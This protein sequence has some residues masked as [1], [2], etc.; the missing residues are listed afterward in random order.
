MTLVF[1]GT[2]EFALPS[3]ETLW[4]SRHRLAAVVTAPDK[5]AGRGLRRQP[6]PVKH[7]AVEN[8]IPILQ[9][10]NLRD[11]KFIDQLRQFQADLFVVVAFRILPPEVFTLPPKGT[12]NLHASLLP[13]Y[14][15]AAPIHWAIINGETET[16]VSTFFLG[17]TVDTG[18][19]ILQERVPI[20][21][22]ETAGE[23]HDKLARVGAEVLLRTVDL[24][25][26][27]KAPRQKQQ[28]E[29]TRAPK[30]TPDACRIDWRK[31]SRSIFNLVRGLAPSPGAFTTLDGKILKIYRTYV[32]ESA[33]T[34]GVLQSWRPE[35]GQVIDTGGGRK[36][37]VATGRGA[38]SILDLQL[39]G[40][41]RMTAEEFLRGHRVKVGEQ[42]GL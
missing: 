16:G 23:L 1:M 14:R 18:D 4:K 11:E 37:T 26:A 2:P 3:L 27:G 42:F 7:F 15:G 29:P 10:D 25:E 20:G 17:E 9:P 24:I 32:D 36:I 39:E 28:G 34:A 33:E 8:R 19:L 13:K 6:S 40:R 22:E 31:D 35:P 5:P 30:I 12:I 21:P 41:R 38:I